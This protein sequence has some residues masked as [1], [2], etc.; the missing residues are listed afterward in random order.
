MSV[1]IHRCVSAMILFIIIP[2]LLARFN[3]ITV[4]N[5]RDQ[6]LLFF[7]FSPPP[8]FYFQFCNAKCKKPFQMLSANTSVKFPK[9]QQVKI[10]V[11]NL[12]Q[13]PRPQCFHKMVKVR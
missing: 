10:A 9:H 8:E 3:K 13:D 4:L 11:E 6:L 2:D 1:E 7:P 12:L 5:E